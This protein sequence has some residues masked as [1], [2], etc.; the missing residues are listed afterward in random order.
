M[1]LLVVRSWELSKKKGVEL[2]VGLV[3]REDEVVEFMVSFPNCGGGDWAEEGERR[4]VG[5]DEGRVFLRWYSLSL[6]LSL[7]STVLMGLTLFEKGGEE[8]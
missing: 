1:P 3:M 5:E 6:S 8:A 2:K 7:C 4:G